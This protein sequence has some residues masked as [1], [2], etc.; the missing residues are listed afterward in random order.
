MNLGTFMKFLAISG[1]LRRS[2]KSQVL[3]QST[4]PTSVTG[5]TNETVLATIAIPA[6]LSGDSI[7]V[8]PIWSCSNATNTNTYSLSL[9]GNKLYSTAPAGIRSIAPIITLRSRG[10]SVITLGAL[11]TGVGGTGAALVSAALDMTQTQILTITGQLGVATDTLVLEGYT[12]E[13]LDAVANERM[14]QS[15]QYQLLGQS[16]VPASVT[17]TTSETVLATVPVPAAMLSPNGSIR[18]TALW[19]YTNNANNKIL[20]TRFGGTEVQGITN[21]TTGVMNQQIVIRARGS[22]NRQITEFN[23]AAG[24]GNATATNF[25]TSVD[26]TEAQNLTLSGVLSNSAD[27]ITLEGYTVEVLNP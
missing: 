7:R 21:T 4:A 14:Q 27:T 16:G 2:R 23:S 19:S 25:T 22:T 8:T 12:V 15:P 10:S 26:T 13:I 9:G 17:G 18:I 5:T 3:A 24:F 11:S 20:F 1:Y 6:L